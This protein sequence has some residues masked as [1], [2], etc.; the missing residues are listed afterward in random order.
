MNLFTK[1]NRLTDLENELM[2]AGGGGWMGGRDIEGIWNGKHIYPAMFKN[3][4][5]SNV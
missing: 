3:Q 2:V 4:Q 5:G 1:R